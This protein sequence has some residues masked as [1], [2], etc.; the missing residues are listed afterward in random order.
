MK[1]SISGR[2]ARM[3]EITGWVPTAMNVKLVAGGPKRSDIRSSQRSEVRRED[4]TRCLRARRRRRRKTA[5]NFAP[6]RMKLGAG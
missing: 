4:Q 1:A 6:R 2:F 5:L 3:Y